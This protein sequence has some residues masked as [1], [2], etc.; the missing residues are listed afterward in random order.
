[1]LRYTGSTA[2]DYSS[3]PNCE[4]VGTD[5]ADVIIRPEFN[6]NQLSPFSVHARPCSTRQNPLVRKLEQFSRLEQGDIQS[7]DKLVASPKAMRAGQLLVHE[8]SVLDEV[9][10]IVQG[11]GC[12]YK[13]LPG[14]ERQIL[15]YLIPGDLCDIHFI[16]LTKPDH[17]VALVS[18][19]QVVKIPTQKLNA[20]LANNPRIERALSLAALHDIAILREWLL[21]VGQRNAL[22]KLSHFFCEMML[23]L[24]R[25]G[26][27]ADDGSFELP[28]NQMALA[29]TTGLTPV[30]INRTLQ[31]LRS[32]GLIRLGQRRL[33]I[34]D[35][36][37]LAAIAGFDDSY[38]QINQCRR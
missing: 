26:Q 21:N 3:S 27:V 30:H 12:R 37:R 38:L 16:T 32:D 13:L 36:T 8:S 28:I 4:N 18:D 33:Y 15:G 35:T 2:I 31:R 10:L 24:S 19:S 29:D 22:Q 1:M 14:G 25:V 17:S 34:I 7:L 5:A 20:L 11:M 6:R 23:R 9:Y